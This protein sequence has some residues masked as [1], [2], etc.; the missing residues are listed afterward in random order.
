[1]NQLL[2]YFFRPGEIAFRY[3][4]ESEEGTRSVEITLFCSALAMGI[5]VFPNADQRKRD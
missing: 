5:A 4:G 3:D 2:P 1:M